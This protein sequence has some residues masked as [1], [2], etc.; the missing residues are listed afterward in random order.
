VEGQRQRRD[1]RLSRQSQEDGVVYELAAART[2]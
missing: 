1:P 2:R